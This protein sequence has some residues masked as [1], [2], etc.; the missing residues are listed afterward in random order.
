[1]CKIRR[2]LTPYVDKTI[3]TSNYF[4]VCCLT[5]QALTGGK[6]VYIRN[7]PRPSRKV[8]TRRSSDLDQLQV[9]QVRISADLL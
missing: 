4:E 3:A 9:P 5:Y 6:P 2:F 1:M 7:M 8:L